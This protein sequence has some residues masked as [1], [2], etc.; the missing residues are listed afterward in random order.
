MRHLDEI[1]FDRAAVRVACDRG[2][3]LGE[4]ADAAEERPD[5]SRSWR[6]SGLTLSLAVGQD[7]TRAVTVHNDSG[8]DV[9]LTSISLEWRPVNGGPNLDAREYVQLH[10][11][12]T[13]EGLAGVRPIHRPNDWADPTEE[14]GMVTVLS[15]RNPGEAL[16]LGA[17]PPYGDCF[18]GFPILHEHTHR[19]G[20]FGIAARLGVPR[21]LAAGESL[22]L[23]HLVALHGTDG[24]ALLDRYASL[25]RDRLPSSL[26]P[27]RRMT[28]WNS[29]DYY[30]GAVAEE[31]VVRNALA[32]RERWG[33]GALNYIVIDEGYESQWG[34]WEAGWK[35]PSGLKSFCDRIRAA[36]SE[37]G[38][39]T[40]P[41][42]VSVY[43]PLYRDHP[44][45][46]ARDADGNPYTVNMGYGAM[47][48][49][50]IT[51]PD[52][53]EH[54]RG[55]Y[56]KLREAGFTYFKCDF[57][58]TLMGAAR[59]ARDDITPA[60]MI[61]ELFRLIR[62]T[63]GDDA[64]LL[65]CGAPYESVVG[66]ANAHRTTGDTH[67]YWSHIRQN[68][69][70][71]LARWWMQGSVGNTDPDFAIVRCESTTDDRRLSRPLAKTPWRRGGN[72]Y[73]GREMNEEEAKTLLLACYAGGGDMIFS[74]ALPLLNE[75]GLKLLD[76][77]LQEP[78]DR[79]VPLNL[80][81]WDGDDLP[82]VEAQGKGRK[83]L[84]LLNMSDDYRSAR[85]PAPYA[86]LKGEHE[87]FWSKER[88]DMLEGGDIFMAPHSAKAWWVASESET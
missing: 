22:T 16:L 62:E 71:M 49:L 5:G 30:A 63:I 23:A 17:L 14:S 4:A 87:E 37:P 18:V 10:H 56:A 70:S 42:H 84:V 65:A 19:D 6:W 82:I 29:W 8:K 72:F 75:R 12:S 33:A 66:I 24:V 26:F 31:D 9:R 43:T 85:L 11:P 52:V 58:Q 64:Y 76:A 57:A 55:V 2:T 88:V 28:G 79:G 60:G 69:R 53:R 46:F 73:T 41:L 54:L 45:W 83:L 7:G 68:V 15:R 48:H 1:V 78:V 38:I 39:W 21:R 80:F 34:V 51:H 25:L 74:D 32:A 36:G 77:M 59:F 44:T 81:R 13:F 3:Y 61:R 47:A 40:A 35:F 67:H 86:G 27:E 50:D 20:A